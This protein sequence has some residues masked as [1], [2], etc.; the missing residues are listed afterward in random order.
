VLHRSGRKI[1]APPCREFQLSK[2]TISITVRN[3]NCHQKKKREAKEE[4][5]ATERQRKNSIRHRLGT[6]IEIES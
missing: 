5:Y 2:A 1:G 3:L 6:S 4:I